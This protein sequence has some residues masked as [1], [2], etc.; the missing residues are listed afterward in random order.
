MKSGSFLFVVLT[1]AVIS[2][3]W[4]LYGQAEQY[5][6][7]YTGISPDGNRYVMGK[8]EFPRVRALDVELSGRP[9]WV[10][11]A[12]GNGGSVWAVVL[13]DGR[14]EAFSIVES[15]VTKVDVTPNLLPQGAPP[16]LVISPFREKSQLKVKLLPSQSYYESYHTHPVILPRSGKTAVIDSRGNLVL[17][18]NSEKKTI[19]INALPDARIV[20][21]EKERLVILTHPTDRYGH[22]ILGDPLEATRITMVGTNGGVRVIRQIPAERGKVFESL[23]PIWVDINGNGMRE[24]IVTVSDSKQGAQIAVYS[25][26]GEII[27]R[28]PSVGRRYRWIHQIAAAPFGPGGEM[29]LVTVRTPHIGGVVEYYRLSGDRLS[30]VARKEGFSTHRIGSRNLDMAAAGDFDGDGSTE[31]LLPNQAFNTLFLLSRTSGGIEIESTHPVD[32]TVQTNMVAVRSENDILEV[33]VG[34][35][36]GVLRVWV[37]DRWR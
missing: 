12:P 1:F 21:D 30:V 10:V 36:D 28:G 11:A 6:F 34:R 25:E 32:G 24:I 37:P 27:G 13:D 3:A 31:L 8:G 18:E 23:S 16:L 33:G 4:I 15:R 20:F 2:A 26:S 14:I 35:E 29:E 9:R 22:G 19:N 17:T 7:G 5:T